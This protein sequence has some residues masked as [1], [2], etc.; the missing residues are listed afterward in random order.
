MSVLRSGEHFNPR[1]QRAWDQLAPEDFEWWVLERCPEAE[2]LGRERHW[3]G[4]WEGPLFNRHP[5]GIPSDRTS[6]TAEHL[7][8]ILHYDPETGVFTWR[9]RADRPAWWNTRHAGQRAGGLQ[10]GK[11]TAYVLIRINGRNYKAHRLAWLY[12]TGEWPSGDIDHEDGD[13]LH[14]WFINL[15]DATRAQNS[16]NTRRRSHNTSGFKGV[17]R[18][19]RRWAAQIM[20][21]GRKCYLGTFDTPELA[22]A[23]YVEAARAHFGEFARPE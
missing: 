22:H 17:T 2:L 11:H 10:W 14:N 13:G 23:A 5:P 12:M 3:Y 20:I 4:A 15:R 1:L 9:E 16:G 21:D 7:R 6:L 8:S 18:K 19:G